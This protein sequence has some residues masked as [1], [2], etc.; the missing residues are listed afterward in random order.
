MNS[1]SHTILLAAPEE[2]YDGRSLYDRLKEQKD[3]KQE[4]FEESRKFKNMIRGGR[5]AKKKSN[6]ISKYL[7]CF[8]QQDWTMTTVQLGTKK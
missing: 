3:A 1:D 5:F 4:E 8:L 6:D 2:A 7:T